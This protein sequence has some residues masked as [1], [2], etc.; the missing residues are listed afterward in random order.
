M[1][2]K[3]LSTLVSR[4]ARSPVSRKL[5]ASTKHSQWLAHVWLLIM[6]NQTV[7]T[8]AA[9]YMKSLMSLNGVPSWPP[10][11]P[12]WSLIVQSQLFSPSPS[13]PFVF[14]KEASTICHSV[15]LLSSSFWNLY[16]NICGGT[17]C[18][19]DFPCQNSDPIQV[20]FGTWV[21]VMTPESFTVWRIIKS[22]EN[23]GVRAMSRMSR[24]HQKFYAGYPQCWEVI[25]PLFAF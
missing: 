8:T 11:C 14:P 21:S 19:Q 23:Q 7:V 10:P 12:F 18:L 4:V 24:E 6:M 25:F 15:L 9:K 22:T 2:G 13:W 20:G 5:P 1:F 16:R 17:Y 3:H